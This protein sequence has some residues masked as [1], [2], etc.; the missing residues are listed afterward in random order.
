ML[1]PVWKFP[2]QNLGRERLDSLPRMFGG[3]EPSSI[4]ADHQSQNMLDGACKLGCVVQNGG[5]FLVELFCGHAA[6]E[7]IAEGAGVWPNFVFH[8]QEAGEKIHV[9]ERAG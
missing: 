1:E 2:V 9:V 7:P 6:P 4:S 3:G 5:I 8:E